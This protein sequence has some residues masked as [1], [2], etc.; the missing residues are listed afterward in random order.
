MN[1]VNYCEYRESNLRLEYYRVL[2]YANK[3]ALLQ[4]VLE[5]QYLQKHGP[6]QTTKTQTVE[7]QAQSF[8]IAVDFQLSQS[9]SST[10]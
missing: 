2:L 4:N 6:A 10:T 7:N 3:I 5:N 1:Q 8:E 9:I